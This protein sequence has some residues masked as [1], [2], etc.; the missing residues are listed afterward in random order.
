[1]VLF[2]LFLA[3]CASPAQQTPAE[4]KGIEETITPAP[5]ELTP[6]AT[7]PGETP[8]TEGPLYAPMEPLPNEE[9]M[10]R[11]TL[12]VGESE[13]ILME[14]Y[15]V[16]VSLKVSGMLPTPCHM[17]RAEATGPDENN[18]I[19]VEMWTL[20]DPDAVCIQVLQPF[21]TNIPLG[22]YETGSYTVFLNGKQVGE[23][24]L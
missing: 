21:E 4:D 15:P 14:S 5:P 22:S 1:M 3:A 11:G 10:I 23:F 18:E 19:H 13:I 7:P 6:S 12:S 16:Q 8:S 20:T 17:P 24:S 2:T 9:E